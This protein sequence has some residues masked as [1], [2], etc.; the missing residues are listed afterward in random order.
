MTWLVWR[1][2]GKRPQ[3][4]IVASARLSCAGNVSF[5]RMRLRTLGSN[6]FKTCVI[7]QSASDGL[8]T[9]GSSM[10]RAL[11]AAPRPAFLFRFA[12]ALVVA[13]LGFSSVSLYAQ[14]ANTLYKRGVAAEAHDDFDTAFN[15]YQ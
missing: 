7:Q 13:V 3:M 8:T 11:S 5:A 1:A 6:V 15:E 4:L 10:N 12:L 14:S 9:P 2:T